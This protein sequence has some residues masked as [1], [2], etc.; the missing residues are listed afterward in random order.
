MTGRKNGLVVLVQSKTGRGE[1]EEV[2]GNA[3]KLG[4]FLR[5]L[6]P[7]FPELS[8]MFKRTMCLFGSTYLCEKLFSTMN[9][10]KSKYRSRLTDGHLQAIVRVSTVSSLKSNVSQLCERKRCQVSGSKE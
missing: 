5:E 1:V 6:P 10:N 9:F 3:D 7:T 4:Q 8:R 2:S